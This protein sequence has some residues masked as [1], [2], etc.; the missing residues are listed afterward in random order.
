MAKDFGEFGRR[1]KK[2]NP[3]PNLSS[4]YPTFLD[5]ICG[6]AVQ[7]DDVEISVATRVGEVVTWSDEFSGTA[8]DSSKWVPMIG[9]GSLYGN[10]GWGNN[11]LQYYTDRPQNIQVANGILRIIARKE[12]FGGKQYTSAQIRSL[13]KLSAQYG[14]FEARIKVPAGQGFWPAF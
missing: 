3:M 5:S 1:S 13:G 2:G 6:G 8:P 9:D 10:P 14:R 11:E 12:N 4:L 7:F